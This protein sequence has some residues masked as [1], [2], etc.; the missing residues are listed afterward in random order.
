VAEK[1]KASVLE[2]QGRGEYEG[3]TSAKA[4]ADSL[5]VHLHAVSNDRHLRVLYS[6]EPLPDRAMDEPPSPEEVARHERA[7]KARNYGYEKAERLPGNVGYLDLRSFM[8]DGPGAREAASHALNFLSNTDALIVDVRNNGGGSPAMVQYVCTYFFGE[9]ERIHLNDLYN[10]PN[11]TTEEFWTLDEVPGRRYT[12]RDLF[13]LT[14]DHTFSAAEEFSYN[15]KNLKRATLVGDTTG[16]GAHPVSGQRLSDHFE[17]MVST[18][19]AISPITKTNWEGT[20]VTPHIAVPADDALRT[21]HLEALK[22]LL[23]VAPNEDE[24][25]RLEMALQHVENGEAASTP[26]PVIRRRA[27]G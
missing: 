24:K 15:L 23:A 14:S 10:R 4:L 3:L 18:G 7:M 8:A 27:G 19:R 9:G 2:R 17:I 6:H 12:G 16:G 25:Q 20:G 1:M 21:A 13:I 22:R 5:T 11:D 26:G